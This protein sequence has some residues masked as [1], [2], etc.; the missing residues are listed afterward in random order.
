MT[1]TA[2]VRAGKDPD[3]RCGR[4][5]PGDLL[6]T[7]RLVWRVAFRIDDR[8]RHRRYSRN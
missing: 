5:A 7:V 4:D 3:R 2:A 6:C 1:L 8:C